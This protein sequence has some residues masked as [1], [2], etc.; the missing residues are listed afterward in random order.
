MGND[1]INKPG[2]PNHEYMRERAEQIA[3]RRQR[4]TYEK[5]LA[6]RDRLLQDLHVHQIELEL[7]NEELRQSQAKLEFTHQQYLDLYNEAPVGYASLDDSGLIIR[8]NQMLASMLGMEKYSL[9]GKA[10]AEF[11]LPIDQNIFRS[12][13]NAFV[14]QPQDKHIDVRF[15]VGDKGSDTSSFIGRIQGRRL[16]SDDR[17]GSPHWSETILIVI[18]DVTEIKKSEEKIH[19]QAFHD[20]LTG[21]PNRASL[22]ERLEN[23]LAL[24]K[25]QHSFGALLFMDLDRFK[26]INDSLGHHTGDKLLIDFTNRIKHQTRKEDMLFR[27]GG[28]EFVVLL[29]EQHHDKNIMAVIAQRFA[30]HITS[31]LSEPIILGGHSF[32]ITLSIGISIFPFQSKDNL[33]DVVRQADTAMYQAKKEGGA[34]ARFFQANMQ[35]MARQ[36]MILEAELR[37]ALVEQQFSLYYQPQM[38]SDGSIY[39]LEALLRWQHPYRGIVTPDQFIH[40]AE[41]TS[42]I[43]EIGNWVLETAVKQIITWQ[44]Q[45]L[46]DPSIR[47]AINVSAKQLENSSFYSQV[48]QIIER[49]KLDPNCLVFE[50]TESLLL[51][52]N[53]VA[54]D[55][56]KQLSELDITFSVDDF[57]TGYSSLA[58]IDNAPIGQLK[59][60]RS[61]ISQLQWSEEHDSPKPGNQYSLVNAILSMGKALELEVIA[62][63]VETEEQLKVLTHL[64]CEYVQGYYFSKPIPVEQIPEIVPSTELS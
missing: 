6:D 60:D 58:T 53:K 57:G 20:L 29:A 43:V 8:S 48:K 25:R 32:Q 61:F 63:G 35:E 30:E 4:I 44:Q 59:I 47:Y 46:F 54:N 24:A 26:N 55:T 41:D 18:S 64:G 9:T 19:Y 52:D 40:V 38:R 50:I 27:M 56:L 5:K 42:M 23:A 49:Y 13:F 16:D 28:D 31:A 3:Q 45:K 1:D 21:I 10:L 37:V 33:N 14:K 11:M 7:Q 2:H 39:A 22:Y 36:R 34:L 62:E 17:S 51:P 15:K 12:R